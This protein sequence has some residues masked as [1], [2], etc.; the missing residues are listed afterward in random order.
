MTLTSTAPMT[1]LEGRY[2]S[3]ILKLVLQKRELRLKRLV[4]ISTGIATKSNPVAIYFGECRS[5]HLHLSLPILSIPKIFLTI[6]SNNQSSCWVNL[7]WGGRFGSPTSFAICAIE[8][9]VLALEYGSC[10]VSFC[11]EHATI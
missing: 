4:K 8:L 5:I 2:G 10:S 1:L 11:T 6:S 3:L 9:H 7:S